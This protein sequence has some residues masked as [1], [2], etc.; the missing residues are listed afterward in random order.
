MH[1]KD[2]IAGKVTQFK[3]KVKKAVGDATDNP[4]L[5][6]EGAVEEASGEIREGFGTAK[7]KVGE[8]VKDIGDAI[9]R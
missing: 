6:E 5:E 7:R 9:K 3:G 1:N 4:N 2:E 8:A